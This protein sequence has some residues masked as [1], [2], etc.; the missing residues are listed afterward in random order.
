M[1]VT[2]NMIEHLLRKLNEAENSRPNC[3]VEETVAAIDAVCAPDFQGRLNNQPFHDRETER[4][5]EK[6]LLTG[7]LDYHRTIGL[8]V[9]DPPFVAFEWK[10]EGT[11]NDAPVEVQGCS[12]AEVNG[13]GLLRRGTVYLDTAQL[14]PSIK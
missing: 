8:T 5:G 13:D 2:R 11:R 9:I 4:Q 10:I 1:A 12:I 14:P 3:T 7:I 6:M